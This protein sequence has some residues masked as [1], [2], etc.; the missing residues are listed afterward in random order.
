MFRIF[1]QN[2]SSETLLNQQ[3]DA[4]EL[5]LDALERALNSNEQTVGVN[6]VPEGPMDD[7]DG[8]DYATPWADHPFYDDA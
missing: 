2:S 4:Y 7:L 5:F 6:Y 1:V 8:D 3:L